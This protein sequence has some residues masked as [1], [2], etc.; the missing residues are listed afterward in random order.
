[1]WD[2]SLVS[3]RFGG[4]TLDPPWTLRLA[5]ESESRSRTN[6]T[7][8]PDDYL[9]TWKPIITIRHPALIVASAARA[10]KKGFPCKTVKS[11]HQAEM[12]DLYASKELYDW[13][14]SRPSKTRADPLK[15]EEDIFPIVLDADD[16]INN[17]YTV[18][19]LA[20]ALDLD[21]SAILYEWDAASPEYLEKQGQVLGAFFGTVEKSCGIITSKSSQ[22]IT[23]ADEFKKWEKEFGVEDANVLLEY[24]ENSMEDYEYL[25]ARRFVGRKR[26]PGIMPNNVV[27]PPSADTTE[28]MVAPSIAPAA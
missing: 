5:G 19:D 2:P 13:F 24:A 8:L 7:L 22:G 6:P 21:P 14:L 28:R 17:K 1:M 20:V 27:R 3:K 15:S 18:H 10:I 11:R 26:T 16:V 4:A 23:L 9:D 25:R 12:C